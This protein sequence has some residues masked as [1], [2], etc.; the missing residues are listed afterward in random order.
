MP[1]NYKYRFDGDK[2]AELTSYITQTNKEQ[3]NGSN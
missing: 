2:V 3:T 1:N